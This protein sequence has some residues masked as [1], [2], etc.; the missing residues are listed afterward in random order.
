[1]TRKQAKEIA[2]QVEE[3]VKHTPPEV[4]E[5]MKQRLDQCGRQGRGGI[6]GMA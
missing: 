1:M 4:I 2:K 3:L 6:G 5:R